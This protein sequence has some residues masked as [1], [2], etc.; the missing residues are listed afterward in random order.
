MGAGL[1]LEVLPFDLDSERLLGMERLG[2]PLTS[3]AQQ[4][5]QDLSMN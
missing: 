4:S 5:I 2:L 1:V 3:G